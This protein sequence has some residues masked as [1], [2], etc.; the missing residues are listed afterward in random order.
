MDTLSKYGFVQ[1][2]SRLI[3]LTENSCTLI[4][5]VYSNNIKNTISCNIFTTDISD[6]LASLTT[7]NLGG[8]KLNKRSKLTNKN[9]T[10]KNLMF[11]VCKDENYQHFQELM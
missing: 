5:H 7:I 9:G 6:L 4:D 10:K 8:K 3:L 1:L 11:T 2:V